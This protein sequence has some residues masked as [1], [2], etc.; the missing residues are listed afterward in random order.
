MLLG[1]LW[2]GAHRTFVARGHIT[3]YC[4]SLRDMAKQYWDLWPVALRKLTTFILVVIGW[5]LFRSAKFLDGFRAAHSYV[6]LE[7]W[8]PPEYWEI[9]CRA[10]GDCGSL[11]HFGQTLLNCGTDGVRFSCRAWCAAPDLHH[12]DLR[13]PGIAISLLPV[14]KAYK[15][16]MID[17]TRLD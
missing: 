7:T 2:H 8:Y 17:G 11:A 12:V 15:G 14:L 16:D 4:W 10:L 1:G 6:L 9:P 5:V 3:D 13:W